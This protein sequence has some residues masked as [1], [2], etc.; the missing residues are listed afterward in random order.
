VT[1]GPGVGRSAAGNGSPVLG[2]ERLA[3]HYRIR[4]EGR[5][6]T[7][8][9][10]DDVSF[11]ILPGETVA[12]VGESGSGKSTTARCVLRL[13]EPSAGRVFLDG[14]EV[15][16]ASSGRLRALR[17]RMQMVFQ[18][19]TESLNPRKTVGFA[20]AEPLKVHG[21]AGGAKR[22]ERVAEIFELCGLAPDHIRRYPHQLS[23][24]QRQRVGIARALVTD[25][26]L[27]LLDEPT[28]ALDVSVQA[29]LLNLLNDV[30]GRLGLSYLFITH[31]LGVVR[32]IADR[33]LVMYAGQIVESAP[34]ELL[35]RRPIH[36]YTR[37]LI[38]AIPSDTPA[39]RG[40][41]QPLPG[42]PYTPIDPD[43]G[44][45]FV[46]RC[47]WAAE[48]C[49]APVELTEVAPGH[50]VR[51]IGYVNG[52]VPEPDEAVERLVEEKRKARAVSPG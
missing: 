12:L 9:A 11:E 24:G 50:H 3:K 4:H 39:G 45:R 21:I 10:V 27:V 36:P 14:E 40:G 17:R 41:S 31:D 28:S 6:R 42:E 29:K 30:Q 49:E 20:V 23:G 22:R 25:P 13:E 44:C 37:V 33:V 51:C 8:H 7:L 35:F 46:P 16:R 15:T 48:E 19:P 34:T 38:E 47:P 18:D 26:T 43:I 2:V 5:R 52:R 32:Y 1:R